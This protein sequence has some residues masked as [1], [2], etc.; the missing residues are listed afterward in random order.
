MP[1]LGMAG[2]TMKPRR[3]RLGV[4]HYERLCVVNHNMKEVYTDVN[5][6]VDEMK[7]KK[8]K[9]KKDKEATEDKIFSDY[10]KSVLENK[11]D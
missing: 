6:V 3:S 1:R 4:C 9:D 5:A 8:H 2:Y 7:T 11:D 10:E